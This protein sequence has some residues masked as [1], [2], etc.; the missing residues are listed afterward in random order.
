MVS[1]KKNSNHCKCS[2][3]DKGLAWRTSA[4]LIASRHSDISAAL[5]Q[6][7]SIYFTQTSN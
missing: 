6:S 1:V 4:V 3:F 2:T 5:K 7:L